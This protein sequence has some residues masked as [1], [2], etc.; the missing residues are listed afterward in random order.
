MQGTRRFLLLFAATIIGTTFVHELGHAFA[1]WLQGVAVVPTPF[2]EYV[3]RPELAWREYAWIAI[4]GVGGSVLS[5]LGIMA[6]YLRR[7]RASGDAV[8]AGAILTPLAYT[9]RYLLVGRGHDGLEWQAA[10]SALGTDPTGHAVDIVFLVLFVAGVAV[11][12]FRRRA[13]LRVSTVARLAGL[14]VVGIVFI[15]VFQVT[16]NRLFDRFFPKTRILDVPS[17]VEATA[18]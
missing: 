12:L 7:D 6:W 4:G 8:L 3:L 5:V 15:I 18:R 1:G 9:V 10:Q 2:K 13:A 14:L 11:W 16:N 17:M